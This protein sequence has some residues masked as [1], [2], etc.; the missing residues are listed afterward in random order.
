MTVTG[1]SAIIADEIARDGPMTFARFMAT[2]LYH[3]I[4]GYYNG[5]GQGREPL[6]WSGDYFTSGDVHPLWG[7]ALARQLHQM[8]EL[9]GHPDH[10]D[11]V[12][13]GAGRGL[14]A[15]ETWRYA[16]R[17]A[18]DWAASLRYTLV[19]RSAAESPL[20]HSREQRLMH[21][22]AAL[23]VPSNGVRWAGS[24]AGAALD[25]PITG[26]AV[27]NELVDALP[28]HVIEVRGGALQEIY[29]GLNG[30]SGTLVEV[31]GP[32]SSPDV[33]G[34]LETYHIPW[35]RFPDG[36]RAEI[37]L[38]AAPWVRDVAALL[39]RGFA[40]TI[41]YGDTARRLYT[42]E[43]RR[44]TLA[45]YTRHQMGDHPLT[46]PGQQ[47]LTAH[48]NF[49]AL[50][51]AGRAAGLRLAGFTTQHEFLRR[52]GIVEEM[53]TIGARRYPAAD[54]ERHTDRGQADLL[55]R[56]ALRGAVSTL[57]NPHGLGGFRVLAQQRGVTGAMRRLRG[58]VRQLHGSAT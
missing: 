9:L 4:L 57:L 45:V 33:A 31:L 32:P 43:R 7:W 20:R 3:P 30:T 27:S 25:G 37:C 2:A 5:G 47:D 18:P 38:D 46:L 48:V 26:C 11:I 10:F 54:T 36:W 8:W 12:E 40:L 21:E 56:M 1:L 52:L 23:A 6:G 53:E 15:R 22:L 39:G 50:I 19:D 41:D 49:T 16:V 13:V 28:V 17:E 35:R 42:P 51:A 14:L 29:V 44:G 34:Y 58:F 24:L 55:R